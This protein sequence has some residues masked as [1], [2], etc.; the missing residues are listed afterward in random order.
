MRFLDK[1]E[2]E[3]SRERLK[4]KNKKDPVTTSNLHKKHI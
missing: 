4:K 3:G 1:K 2:V